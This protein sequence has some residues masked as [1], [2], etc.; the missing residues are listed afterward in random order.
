MPIG[1]YDKLFGGARG[2]A[3]KARSTMRKT[4]GAKKGEAVFWGTVYRRELRAKRAGARKT[5]ARRS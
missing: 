2:A 1:G 5:K 4:Y 3:E